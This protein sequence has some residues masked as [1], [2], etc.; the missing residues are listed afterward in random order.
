MSA[1]CAGRYMTKLMSSSSPTSSMETKRPAPPTPLPTRVPVRKAPSSDVIQWL[2]DRG[3][4]RAQREDVDPA[5]SD[6]VD[7]ARL[8][9]SGPGAHLPHLERIQRS[10]GRHDVS[11][12]VAHM[13]DAAEAGARA[14][15][16]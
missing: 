1:C 16:A 11:G 10:F 4:E 6:I 3:D 9:V 12:V 13:D 14:M 5:Y 8:G 7:A 2:S 15:G